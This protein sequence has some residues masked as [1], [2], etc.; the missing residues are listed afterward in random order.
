MAEAGRPG[1]V[2]VAT[3]MAGRGT[4]IVLGGNPESLDIDQEHW[5]K[6]HDFVVEHGGL[7]IL[8]T[9]RH[10]A[11]RI[12][13]QLRGRAGRQ[14]DPGET[15]FYVALDDELMRRFGGDRIRSI[16][17]WAGLEDDVPIEN[18]MIG[19]AIEGAQVK[20]EAYHFDIRKHLVE[21]DDV[22]NTH[23]DVIYGE[24]DKIL[25]GA[26]LK[27]N[28]EAMIEHEV[29]SILGQHVADKARD[30]WDTEGLLREAFTIMPLRDGL[31]DP[32]ALAQLDAD[33]IEDRLLDCAGAQYEGMERDLTPEITREIERQVLLRVTDTAW[34]QH[35][36]SMESLR[37]GIGL[38]SYGQRDPLVM[39]KREGHQR[40]Q[41]L[42]DRIQRD[43]ART[44]FHVAV[45]PEGRGNGGRA[46]GR[47]RNE[48]PMAQVAGRNKNEPVKGG[49]AKVGRN[50][51]CPCGSGKKYKRC[52]GA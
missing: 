3:N 39:Y 47:P 2:T 35:L 37:Q 28:V 46:L 20:V 45:R 9:E 44:I 29:Q 16:M 50:E 15:R 25:G 10:E 43:V 8:G 51:P 31:S 27:S 33:E 26:D 11:R 24:R 52:H 4:D 5:E 17:D 14:G 38:H 30:N 7:F 48:S 18:K 12:D 1:A 36:T 40:F 34:V 32:D 6:D 19:R 21:Y 13:N 22:V 41:D 49:G 42:R 23:R